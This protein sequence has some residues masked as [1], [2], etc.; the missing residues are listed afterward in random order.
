MKKIQGVH[1]SKL[2]DK[3]L[4]LEKE[5]EVFRNEIKRLRGKVALLESQLNDN[6]LH[7]NDYLPYHEDDYY[8]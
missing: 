5:N 1:M 8:R 7:D 4:Q 2:E 6:N 3:I